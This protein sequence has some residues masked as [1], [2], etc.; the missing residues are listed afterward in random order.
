MNEFLLSILQQPDDGVTAKWIIGGLATAVVALSSYVV[1]LHLQINS[2][3]EARVKSI[4]D[5]FDL[6]KTL[7]KELDK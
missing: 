4:Q 7:R 6:L 1:K 3:Q 2:I 5:Q